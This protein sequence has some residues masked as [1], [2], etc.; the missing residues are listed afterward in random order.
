LCAIP[1]DHGVTKLNKKDA[2]PTPTRSG[3]EPK[4]QV[5]MIWYKDGVHRKDPESVDPSLRGQSVIFYFTVEF[6]V[7]TMI[8]TSWYG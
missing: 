7:A 2:D 3:V 5:S 6:A 8:V 1:E 4:R